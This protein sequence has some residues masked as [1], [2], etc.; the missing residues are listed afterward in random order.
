MMAAQGVRQLAVLIA[1]LNVRLQPIGAGL[2]LVTGAP[3]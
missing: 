2:G 1:L 3:G